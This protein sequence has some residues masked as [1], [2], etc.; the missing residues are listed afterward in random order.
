MTASYRRMAP[1]PAGVEAITLNRAFGS[2]S[3]R[4]DGELAAA[5]EPDVHVVAVGAVHEEP[6]D[7]AVGA[8]EVE[9]HRLARSQ[10]LVDRDRLHG[11]ADELDADLLDEVA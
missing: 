4:G 11:A 9:R 2:R 7:R 8:V 10:G 5:R 1:T 3:D 6:V